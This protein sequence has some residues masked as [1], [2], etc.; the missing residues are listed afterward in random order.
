MYDLVEALRRIYCSTTGYDYAHVFVPE[1]RRWLRNAAECG[2]FRAPADPIDPVALL[3]RLTQIEAF[4]R[5]LH[6]SFPGKTRFS[7]EGVD[8]MVPI[9]DEVIAESA[10]AGTRNI[11]IGMAHRGRLNVMAHVLNKPYAQILAEFKDP[12][13]SKSFREDMAWTGDVKYHAGAHRA[14]KGGEALDLVVSMPPNPSHLEAVD[15]IVEGMARA[16]GTTVEGPGAPS[17]IPRAACRS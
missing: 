1:E 14:I 3:D 17:S 2:R 15:P 6:R 13:S 4:E 11:L 8:M 7:I 10:E 12:V 5:F 9:L 16:A